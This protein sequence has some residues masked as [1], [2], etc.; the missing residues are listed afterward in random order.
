MNKCRIFL[1]LSLLFLST[2][3]C[4]M[5][6]RMKIGDIKLPVSESSFYIIEVKSARLHRISLEMTN[7]I[8]IPKEILDICRSSSEQLC[9]IRELYGDMPWILTSE[10]EKEVIAEGNYQSIDN[11]RPRVLPLFTFKAKAGKYK[12]TFK[13][14]RGYSDSTPEVI[15]EIII[16]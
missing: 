8:P 15:K 13:P 7:A 1:L 5:E 6:E 2:G 9:L 14:S 4:G 16:E 11:R 10:D 12:L 3:G